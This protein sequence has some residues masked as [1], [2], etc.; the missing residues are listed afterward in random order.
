MRHASEAMQLAHPCLHLRRH[1]PM[2][3]GTRG[4]W[5]CRGIVARGN[6]RWSHAKNALARGAVQ[7]RSPAVASKLAGIDPSYPHRSQT[8]EI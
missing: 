1:E 6:A 7:T 5:T 8:M 3:L 2:T 4:A